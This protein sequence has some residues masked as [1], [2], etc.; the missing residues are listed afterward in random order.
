[1]KKL[2]IIALMLLPFVAMS[3]KT[4]MG[5]AYKASYSSN[6]VMAGSSYSNKVLACWKDFENNTFDKHASLFADTLTVMFADSKPKKGKAENMEDVK[7]FRSSIKDYKVNVRAWI[8]MKSVDK[9]DNLVCIWGNESFTGSDGKKVARGL[10]E[11][12]V[13]NKD[14]KIATIVQFARI[15]E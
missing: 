2:L 13:F 5:A 9:G 11:V 1:M 8:S 6:W 14:G 12:W 3:Q 4:H 15:P 7:K 10:H